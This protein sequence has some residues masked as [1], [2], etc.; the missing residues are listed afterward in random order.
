VRRAVL[1]NII[2]DSLGLCKVPTLSLL[3][4]FDLENEAV[5]ASAITGL[6]LYADDLF[7][8]GERVAAME[9][10]FNLKHAPDMDEDRLPEMFFREGD[11]VL[12]PAVLQQMLIEFYTAMGWDE[13]GRPSKTTLA[14]LGI[15]TRLSAPGAG[16]SAP[17]SIRTETHR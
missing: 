15:D 10:L 14:A 17:G 7:R 8:I 2:V 3:G 6:S 11:S 9:R 4:T 16:Q 5:L 12:T 1:V 13:N